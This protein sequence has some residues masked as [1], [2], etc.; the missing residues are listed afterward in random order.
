MSRARKSSSIPDLPAAIRRALGPLRP[1]RGAYLLVG[2]SGGADSTALACALAEV[3]ATEGWIPVLAHLHHGL[4]GKAA[5]ADREFVRRLAHALSA[6]FV[7]GRAHVAEAARH[8]RV[9]I[10]MAA[11]MARRRFLATEAR[12]WN[13]AA[14][15]LGHTRDDQAETVLLRLARGASTRGLGGMAPLDT[16]EEIP[17]VRPWLE[18]SRAEVEIWL[19]ARR[20]PWRED[21]SNRDLA[22]RR[23]R[24]RRRILPLIEEL[25]NPRA[26][27]AMAR[28]ARRLREDEAALDKIARRAA[29]RCVTPDGGWRMASL[30][31]HSPAIRRRLLSDALLRAGYP[32][33]K[34]EEK[35]IERIETL[36]GDRRL[37]NVAL[38]LGWRAVRRERVLR[39]LREPPPRSRRY[40]LPQPVPGVAHL[41]GA[42][43]VATFDR[44]YRRNP[45]PGAGRLPDVAWLDRERALAS[46]LCWRLWREGDRIRPLGMEGSRKLQDVFTDARTPPSVRRSLPILVSGR[47]VVW[48]PGYRIARGWAAK[49]CRAP[50][51]RLQCEPAAATGPL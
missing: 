23:N 21:A 31:R 28:A 4:R 40:R 15:L 9:S 11:R 39:L 2:A 12:R 24:V 17:L 43:A 8:S 5:D 1:A 41:P 13:A 48:V 7:S 3:A 19:R 36:L 16:L 10:E 34:L 42:I 50:T 18:V 37:E 47:E 6:R 46:R 51:V 38:G 29:A 32:A 30:R 45:P 26:K 22:Y 14:I 25:L 49:S 27:E 33:E 44:G 35:L 20:Q